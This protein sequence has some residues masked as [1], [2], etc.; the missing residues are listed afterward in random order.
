MCKIDQKSFVCL[1]TGDHPQTGAIV[2]IDSVYSTADQHFS[3][4]VHEVKIFEGV[5]IQRREGKASS[6]RASRARATSRGHQLRGGNA[7]FLQ[8]HREMTFADACQSEANCR[9]KIPAH[10]TWHTALS[11]RCWS[12]PWNSDP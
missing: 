10:Q 8:L 4:G 11:R 9:S 3:R 1:Y 5:F 7:W 6:S 2:F 12:Y